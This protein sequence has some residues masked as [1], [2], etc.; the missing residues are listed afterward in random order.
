[1]RFWL[2]FLIIV[3]LGFNVMLVGGLLNFYVIA[4]ND[5]AMPVKAFGEFYDPFGRERN[6]IQ[7]AHDDDVNYAFLSDKHVFKNIYYSKG[8]VLIVVGGFLTIMFLIINLIM[9]FKYYYKLK[10]KGL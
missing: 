9:F 10:H 8:D 3:S 6:F 7:F 4:E 1:M 5:G 2:N